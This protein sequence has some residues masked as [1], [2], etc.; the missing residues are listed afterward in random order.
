M[1]RPKRLENDMNARTALKWAGG[2][3]MLA[4]LFIACGSSSQSGTAEPQATPATHEEAGHDHAE[5]ASANEAGDSHEHGM[6]EQHM[7]MHE[8][9]GDTATNGFDGM[10]E[11]GATAHCP[12]MDIDFEVSADSPHSEYNG[13]TYVF[14][15][16]NCKG[17]FDAD[18]A[19]YAIQ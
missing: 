5:G 13:K 1:T 19:K 17:K 12:V 4:F 3:A 7:S 8:T 18:P 16:P 15:C 11:P 9:Q 6:H 10:P 14:C 2:T